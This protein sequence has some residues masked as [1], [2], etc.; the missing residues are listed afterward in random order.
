MSSS[1]SDEMVAYGAEIGRR[2]G[3]LDR[4][5]EWLLVDGDR[6]V[7]AIG[8]AVVVYLLLLALGRSGVIAFVNNDSVTRVAGGMVAGTLSLVTLVVSINQLIL[9][10]EFTTAGEFRERV[11]GVMEFRRDVADATAVPASP[12]TP[13]QL[14]G[15]LV[16]AIRR[17]ASAVSE[18]VADHP[19]DDVR[20]RITRYA[21]GVSDS[22]DRID[23]TLKGRTSNPFDAVSAAMHYDDSW[24]I[25]AARRLRNQHADSLSDETTE[26]LTELIDALDL[27]NV[28][29]E[30]FKT[31]HLQRELTRFSQLTIYVGVPAVLAAVLVG[32]LYAD[33]SGP[34][35]R[36]DYL[37]YVTSALIAV[38][39]LPLA[40]LAAFVLRAATVAKRTASIGPM[41]PE[42]DP[43]EGPFEPPYGDEE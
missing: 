30:H 19:D 27:L 11:E 1:E 40:L 3:P 39:V 10:R 26:A 2:S 14:L 8:I 17:R 43:E 34:A 4:A 21:N 5:R 9:S 31:T 13:T 6:L 29:R 24:Q 33:V 12:P 38:A 23:E 7:I 18:A 15:V 37:P 41:L 25:H 35:I 36:V 32:L 22:T 20:R 28:A 16:A 42:K